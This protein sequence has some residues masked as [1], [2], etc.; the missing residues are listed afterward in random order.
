MGERITGV[1]VLGLAEDVALLASEVRGSLLQPRTT[2][3]AFGA[4]PVVGLI[5]LRGEQLDPAVP[6]QVL[7]IHVID[8]S[9]D[10]VLPHVHR[11]R[12]VSELVQTT[13]I[14]VLRPAAVVVVPAVVMPKHPPTATADDPPAKQ[15]GPLGVRVQIEVAS[16][17]RPAL[18]QPTLDQL[19]V[20]PLRNQRLV[21]RLDRPHPH[22]RWVDDSGAAPAA[23]GAAVVDLVAGVLRV[24][25]HIGHCRLRPR[26]PGAPTARRFRRRVCFQVRVQPLGDRVEAQ[27]LVIAPLGH[28]RDR[29]GPLPVR[30]QAG[31]RDALLRLDRIGVPVL[32]RPVAVQRL[33]DV[34][35]LADVRARPAPGLLQHVEHFVLSYRLVDPPLQDLLGT[36]TGEHDRLVRGEHR[37]AGV[38]QPTLDAQRLVHLARD[39][40]HRLAHHDVEP[41]AWLG[42]FGQQVADPTVASDRDVEAL[43]VRLPAP[44]VQLHTSGL[45]VV[46]V[47]DDHPGFRQCDL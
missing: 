46:E 16:V 6:E 1:G 10:G 33:A 4:F 9:E 11:L 13:A 2:L 32:L 29:L 28:Q 14:V 31:L 5:Q 26:S 36:T 24:L 44:L 35:A 21:R 37:H 41:S 12:M 40:R 23:P 7:G 39:P 45:D 18:G 22:L 42:R 15:I 38:L 34:V 20:H 47:R 17:P 8:G 30:L 19:V 3:A 27:L 43:V 25:Q